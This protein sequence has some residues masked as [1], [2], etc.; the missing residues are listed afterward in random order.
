MKVKLSIED[1]SFQNETH[2]VEYIYSR[3]QSQTAWI[4][5]IEIWSGMNFYCSVQKVF[6]KLKNWLNDPHMKKNKLTAYEELTQ[7]NMSLNEFLLKFEDLAF[8]QMKFDKALI[9]DVINKLNWWFWNWIIN[10]QI[11]FSDWNQ[12]CTWI[13]QINVKQMTV[14]CWVDWKRSR[15][16]TLKNRMILSLTWM[17]V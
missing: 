4:L 12:F 17:S 5:N 10:L 16:R 6:Q 8:Y 9:Y 7:N 15:T 3:M 2:Q 13:M 14:W 1:D 11:P